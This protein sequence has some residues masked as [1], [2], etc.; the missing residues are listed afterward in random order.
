MRRYPSSVITSSVASG[1]R[2]YSRMIIS[3]AISISPS[4]AMRTSAPAT[5]RPIVPNLKA[6]GRL[7]VPIDVVS[8]IPHPSNTGTPA[9]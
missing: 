1:L 8:V 7:S 9:A 5:G 6:S 4:S 3:P 2:Q